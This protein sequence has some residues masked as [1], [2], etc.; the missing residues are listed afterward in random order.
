MTTILNQFIAAL[1]GRGVPETSGDD[2]LW[3]LAMLEAAI[4]SVQERRRVSIAEVF[5]PELR[6]AA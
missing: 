5:P 3:T 2:N 1:Q 6:P 4:R